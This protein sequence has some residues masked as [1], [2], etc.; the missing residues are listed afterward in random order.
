LSKVSPKKM[1][2]RRKLIRQPIGIAILPKAVAVPLYKGMR[3]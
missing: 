3:T 1:L 2:G